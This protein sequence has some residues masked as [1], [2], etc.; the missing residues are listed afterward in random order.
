[1]QRTLYGVMCRFLHIWLPGMHW[2]Y[3]WLRYHLR[4]ELFRW[5]FYILRWL[6]RWLFF[7]MHTY[8]WFRMYNRRDDYIMRG[9]DIYGVFKRMWNEL[10]NELSVHSVWQLRRMRDFLFAKLQYDM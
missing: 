7:W 1:M 5:L 9:G 8:L 6:F 10:C 2:V 3:W 4:K